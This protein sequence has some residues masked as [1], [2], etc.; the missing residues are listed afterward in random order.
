MIDAHDLASRD[1]ALTR[2]FEAQ[3]GV[4]SR[5]FAGALHRAGRRLPRRLRKQGA[6][7]L[8]AQ[9]LAGNPKLAQQI[10]ARD[11]DRAYAEITAHLEAIDV[12]DLRRGRLLGLAGI[13]AANFLCRT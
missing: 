10:D 12:A 11:V 5:T 8:N 1:K 3:L 7:I 4:K 2:V 9:H 13:I 6:V